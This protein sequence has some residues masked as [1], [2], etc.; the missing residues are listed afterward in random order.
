MRAD[1]VIHILT[2]R[3]LALQA[4]AGQT[5]A[6]QNLGRA[7]EL[8]APEGYVR[9][10]VDVGAPL[11]QL[12]KL[13]LRSTFVSPSVRRYAEMLLGVMES[14]GATLNLDPGL[15]PSATDS[16]ILGESLT[17]REMEVLR[18]LAAGSSNQAIARELVVEL[19]TVKRHVSN[20]MDKLQVQSRLEAVVRAR[21]LG[22]V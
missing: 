9:V 14:E 22:I 2:L 5:A 10:F 16:P 1:S 21:D 6:L 18:L 11:A 20:I 7:I 19:G 8:A 3:A 13:G 12:L 15:L 4:Q 17:A